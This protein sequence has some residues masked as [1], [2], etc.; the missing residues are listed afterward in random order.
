MTLPCERDR[1][2]RDRDRRARISVP[3]RNLG[4]KQPIV[5]MAAT[6]SGKGYWLVA[7]DGGIFTFGDAHFYGSTGSHA[8][9]TNRSSAWPPT[10]N[11]RG[12]WLVASDGGIFSF[13]DARFYG[14]TG[15]C[16]LNQPIVGMAR[17]ADRARLLARRDRRRHLH[18]R[19]RALLRLDRR[20]TALNQP[21][22]GMAATPTGRGYWL[23]AGDGGIFTFGNARFHGSATNARV[24]DTDRRHRAPRRP[25]TATGSRAP[26]AE[27]L[28]FGDARPF[29]TQMAPGRE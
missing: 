3:R 29:G 12:Y 14:S 10:P 5:G 17:H 16:A 27:R 25:G 13:G 7:S 21:I 19:R 1:L 4:L 24:P 15:A 22:V 8:R 9:S 23:V 2:R 6:P 11:G 18:V 26:T 28:A 20:P